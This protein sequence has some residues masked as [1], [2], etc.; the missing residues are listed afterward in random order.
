MNRLKCCLEIVEPI[1][2]AHS[3]LMNSQPT[4]GEAADCVL[5]EKRDQYLLLK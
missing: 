5:D 4:Q 1:L 3:D 2:L